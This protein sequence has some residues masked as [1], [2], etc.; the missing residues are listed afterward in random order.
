MM[1]M[2]AAKLAVWT[3]MIC[4]FLFPGFFPAEAELDAGPAPIVSYSRQQPSSSCRLFDGRPI[5]MR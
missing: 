2:A 5:W 4:L 3:S 1:H